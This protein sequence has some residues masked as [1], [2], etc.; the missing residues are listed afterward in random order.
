M[1]REATAIATKAVIDYYVQRVSAL[2]NM[3]N[4]QKQQQQG[5]LNFDNSLAKVR[6][7]VVVGNR[8]S[9]FLTRI[10]DFLENR[11]HRQTGE[12]HRETHG[13]S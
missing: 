11:R 5:T 12:L 9:Y 4:K 8:G 2:E 13:R 3:L 6:I 7:V 1:Y 10:V